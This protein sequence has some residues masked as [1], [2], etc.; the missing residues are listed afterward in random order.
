[1]QSLPILRVGGTRGYKIDVWAN[2]RGEPGTPNV[3]VSIWK[4]R[5][6][7]IYVVAGHV[8]SPGFSASF[9]HL[10]WIDVHYRPGSAKTIKGCGG[11]PFRGTE[12]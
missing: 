8:S 12:G 7:T 4:G 2:P 11:R 9:R 5:A 10:G 1:M 6:E 3:S